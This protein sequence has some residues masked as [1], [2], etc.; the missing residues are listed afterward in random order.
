MR[1]RWAAHLAAG[2]DATTAARLYRNV[3]E[4]SNVPRPHGPRE[5]LF[6]ALA[7]DWRRLLRA[8]WPDQATAVRRRPPQSRLPEP[9]RGVSRRG[10]GGRAEGSGSGSGDDHACRANGKHERAFAGDSNQRTPRRGAPAHRP[11]RGR[12]SGH[13]GREVSHAAVPRHPAPRRGV[14][15]GLGSHERAAAVDERLEQLDN[16]LELAEHRLAAEIA[17]TQEQFAGAIEAELNRWDA[18][19][20]R[21]QAKAAAQAGAGARARRGGDRRAAA[22]ARL[23]RQSLAAAGTAAGENWRDAKTRVLPSSTT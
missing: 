15:P 9:D 11:P 1:V 10:S 16:E 22:A 4:W 20:A 7:G 19:L 21:M 3:L 17:T 6:L 8:D 5:S 13:G 12:R 2:G 18:Y 23:N 14:R